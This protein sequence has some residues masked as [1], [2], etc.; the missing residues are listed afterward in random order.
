MKISAVYRITNTI[1]GDFYIGSSKN[2]KQRWAAHKCQSTWKNNSNNQMYIDMQ[3][4]GVEKFDFE[5]IEEAEEG[6]LKE[7]EQQFIEK[8]KPTY[9]DRNANG[10]DIER[11]KDYQKSDKRK[12]YKKEYNKTDK[13]KK[14]RKKANN[15]YYSQ[16]CCYNGETLTLNALRI[17]FKRRGIINP[18]AEAKKYLIKKESKTPI[19]FYDVYP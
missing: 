16:L 18:I 19:E 10:W 11:Y 2:V 9:N 8:L 5:V 12:K 4:Y 7:T 13:G 14:S 15:K 3:K 6:K 17:R 1:T